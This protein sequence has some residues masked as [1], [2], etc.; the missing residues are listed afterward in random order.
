[1]NSKPLTK[2]RETWNLFKKKKFQDW[3]GNILPY[4]HNLN[5]ELSLFLVLLNYSSFIFWNSEFSVFFCFV[6]LLRF[7]RFRRESHTQKTYENSSIFVESNFF[8]FGPLFKESVQRSLLDRHETLNYFA[9]DYFFF[10]FLSYF[11]F[12]SFTGWFRFFFFVV[13]YSCVDN[14][15]THTRKDGACVW[16][17]LFNSV[18]GYLE[19]ERRKKL[20]TKKKKILFAKRRDVSF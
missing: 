6:A 12:Q 13:I 3:F 18:S 7:C 16:Q 20:K 14:R 1:M 11:G 2:E 9:P 8:S 4:T 10:F 19:R 5:V 15:C 17:F